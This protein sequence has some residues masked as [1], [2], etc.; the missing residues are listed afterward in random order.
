MLVYCDFFKNNSCFV[1]IKWDMVESMVVIVDWIK[2]YEVKYGKCE[3][4][5]FLDVVLLI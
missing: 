5:K 3:V 2:E 4:E 1:N